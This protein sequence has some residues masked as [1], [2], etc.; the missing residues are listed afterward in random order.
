MLISNSCYFSPNTFNNTTNFNAHSKPKH[1]NTCINPAEQEQIK[2]YQIPF[3]ALYNVKQKKFDINSEKEKLL[4]QL[5]DLL[6]SD[7]RQNETTDVLVLGRKAFEAFRTKMRKQN[8]ILTQLDTI[9]FDKILTPTQKTEMINQLKK[10]VKQLEKPFTIDRPKPV[11]PSDERFDYL[12]LNKFKTAVSEDNFNL[13]RVT[14]D[15]YD[16]LK[17]IKSVKELKT[18]YPVIK[19]PK[20]PEE[21]VAA[22]IESVLTRDFYETVDRLYKKG[23]E[24]KLQEFVINKIAEVCSGLKLRYLDS[25]TFVNKILDPVADMICDKYVNLI[26]LSSFSSVPEQRKIKTPKISETDMKLLSIDFDDFV[27]SV[28]RKH[29]LDFQKLNE[30]KY[31]SGDTSI[32][33]NELRG[34]EY[35]FEK[36]PEKIKGFITSADKL[37]KAQRDYDNYD[38]EQFKSRLNFYANSELGNDEQMLENIINFDTCNFTEED[39]ILL[40]K[41][42]RELDCIN[43]GEISLVDG[44]ETIY[45]NGYRPQGTEKLNLLEKEKA[46]E[47]FKIEQQKTFKL[48]EIK[49]RFDNTI[50]LLYQNN[51][52]NV[53]DICSKYR[54]QS[55]KPEE[56]N[57]S[58]FVIKTINNALNTE[59][60]TAVNSAKLES[61]IARWDIFNYYKN[62]E[63]QNSIF[64]QAISRFREQDGSIDIDKAG[65]YIMNSEIIDLYP[66]SLEIVQEPEI[67]TRIMEMSGDDT[68]AAVEYFSKFE[69]YKIL[70][71]DEKTYL[72][73]ILEKFDTKDAVDKMLLKYILEKDYINSDT[74][75]LI[76]IND[77]NENNMPAE[78]LAS[79]KQQI[80]NKYKFPTCIQYLS[81]FEDALSSFASATGTSGI[82]ITGRNNKNIEYK[83]ELKIKGHDDRLFSSGND[84]RFDIFS[85]RGMH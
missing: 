10:E 56:I 78:I 14:R 57:N 70:N 58:E 33:I 69:D 22:K 48:N 8:E 42:L 26:K 17:N 74:K 32:S 47:L 13:K 82:K 49:N 51:L 50:N 85:D 11:K 43:D 34:S 31:Q 38:I 25:K 3:K 59:T 4:K 35:K 61:S 71:N 84:Y 30:I 53:A 44:L 29:Y 83:M 15:Y 37:L 60:Q 21:V 40:K 55:L 45:S 65:Q 12:L 63:P 68:Q 80:Y 1:Y 64:Q 24:D 81:A 19:L 66:G 39:I 52:N 9:A 75:V 18:R 36:M 23:S 28:L 62:N 67:L 16:G 72:S 79:A 54:P 77:T 73:K 2:Y 7:C 6:V 76:S 41:F 20:R 5:S 46:A 27:L